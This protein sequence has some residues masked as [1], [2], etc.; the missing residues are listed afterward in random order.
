MS[1]NVIAATLTAMRV[2]R[3]QDAE[4]D[5]ERRLGDELIVEACIT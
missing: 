2:K 5:N 3:P 1:I 4:E